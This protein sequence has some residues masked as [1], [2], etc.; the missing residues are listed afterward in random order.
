VGSGWLI[1][2]PTDTVTE[3]RV[4]DPPHKQAGDLVMLCLSILPGILI[5]IFA[6]LLLLEK[7]KNPLDK[8]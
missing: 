2:T 4:F 5:L 7:G 8:G 1:V 3:I 6:L